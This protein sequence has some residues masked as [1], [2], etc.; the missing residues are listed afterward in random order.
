MGMSELQLTPSGAIAVQ[1]ASQPVE[2]GTL[3]A[4]AVLWSTLPAVWPQAYIRA[5]IT[6]QDTPAGTLS[7]LLCSGYLEFRNGPSWSGEI[8]MTKG[9]ELTLLVNSDRAT[10]IRMA[11]ITRE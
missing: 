7:L 10:P 3:T 5:G 6:N 4:L 11:W 8:K 2:R 9:M 1:S